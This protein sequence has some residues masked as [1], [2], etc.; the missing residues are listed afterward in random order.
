[1]IANTKN[2]L[3]HAFTMMDAL[4]NKEIG[5]EEAKAQANLIKQSNNII[6]NELD[7]AIALAKYENIEIRDIE[8]KDD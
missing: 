2:L 5:I 3:N 1:M 7:R 4:K 8:E 6:K